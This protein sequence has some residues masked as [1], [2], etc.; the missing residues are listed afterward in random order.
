MSGR[1]LLALLPALIL[2]ACG[3]AP[4]PPPPVAA[5]T[6]RI[7]HAVVGF[8]SLPIEG[9]DGFRREFRADGTVRVWWPDGKLAAEGRFDVVDAQTVS[10]VY[11]NRDT[12]VVHLLDTNYM[13]I[14][15]VELNGNHRK[16]YA[17]REVNPVASPRD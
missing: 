12:D 4:E 8:W 16:Y 15:R 5:S 3:P 10:V 14:A 7:E 6:N 1:L 9:R 2:A 13:Q 11:P 17:I